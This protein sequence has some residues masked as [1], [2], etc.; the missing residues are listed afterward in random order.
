MTPA[1]LF[2]REPQKIEKDFSELQGCYYN[3]LSELELQL[4]DLDKAEAPGIE[5]R[6]YGYKFYDERRYWQLS[7]VYFENEPV[8][9]V[10]NAGR[11]GD[12]HSE[13]FIV[14]VDRYCAMLRVIA[15]LPRRAGL[16]PADADFVVD[17][18]VDINGLDDFYGDSL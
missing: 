5:L 7:A 10:Q 6:V 15:A 17:M 13:R 1:E 9:I 14:D 12:D 2:A 11:E 18:N 8:M 16:I 3:H 4:G